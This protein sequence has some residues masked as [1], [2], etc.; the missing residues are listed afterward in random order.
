MRTL[1]PISVAVV[2]AAA[3]AQPAA[4]FQFDNFEEGNFNCVDNVTPLTGI[5]P[6]L[7]EN[8]AL[9]ASNVW[10]GVRLVRVIAGS[11]GT[12]TG[13]AVGTAALAT[14]PLDDGAALTVAGVPEGQ[15]DYEFVYDGVPNGVA[16][17]RFGTL[18]LDLTPATSIDVSFTTL[19]A[20]TATVQVSLSSSTS[21]QFSAQVPLVNGIN[22]FLLSGFNILDLSDIQQVRV[23]V[24]GIDNGEAAVINYIATSPDIVPEP[25]TGFLVAFGLV[26]IAV[27]RRAS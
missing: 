8:S 3:L 21:T 16:D 10:G 20:I 27:R 12:L 26:G 24:A 9:T 7:C 25:G 17:G 11:S 19:A 22:S 1:A 15:A 6:T 23:L 18:N 14:T 4:S 5:G 2:L 13:L